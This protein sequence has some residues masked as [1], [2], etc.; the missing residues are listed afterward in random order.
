[1]KFSNYKQTNKNSMDCFRLRLRNDFALLCVIASRLR[2]SNPE[3]YRGK[4]QIFFEYQKPI[5]SFSGCCYHHAGH[6]ISENKDID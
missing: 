4:V 2:R 1:M 3:I 6:S 5:P